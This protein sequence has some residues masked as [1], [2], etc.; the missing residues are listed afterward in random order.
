M[1]M[2]KRKAGVQSCGWYGPLG[3]EENLPEVAKHQLE[4]KWGNGGHESGAV[5]DTTE[6]FWGRRR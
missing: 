2:A 3:I 4:S 5:E 1:V 6:C